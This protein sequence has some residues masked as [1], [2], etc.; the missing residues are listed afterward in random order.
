MRCGSPTSSA[1]FALCIFVVALGVSSAAR[2]QSTA[3]AQQED[4]VKSRDLLVHKL[5]P[6]QLSNTVPR[7]YALIIGIS[8][9]E[10]LDPAENLRF[11]ESD[12]QGIYR[13]LISKEAG[14]LPSENV[15][16][17]VGSQATR[18]RIR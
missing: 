1:R 10:N 5:A 8:K 15:H 9:Y 12:A 7:G 11:P 2:A 3:P 18:D 14:A 4:S 13:V 16:L 17:L 6:K